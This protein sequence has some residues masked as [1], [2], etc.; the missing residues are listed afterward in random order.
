[1]ADFIKTALLVIIFAFGFSYMSNN[2]DVANANLL[3]ANTQ[4][5]QEIY[6]EL[7]KTRTKIIQLEQHLQP[8]YTKLTNAELEQMYLASGKSFP[9]NWFVMS[10]DAQRSYLINALP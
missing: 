4:A 3:Q 6:K 10:L 7:D 2:L 8:D 5:Q 9:P 1:M